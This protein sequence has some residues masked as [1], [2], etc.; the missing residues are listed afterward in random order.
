[1][2][3][4]A[5]ARGRYRRRAGRRARAAAPW[6]KC[7]H[8]VKHRPCLKCADPK[9]LPTRRGQKE[10]LEGKESKNGDVG[11]MQGRKMRIW[12]TLFCR[13][14]LPFVARESYALH[15]NVLAWSGLGGKEIR[16]YRCKRQ[17]NSICFLLSRFSIFNIRGHS[18]MTSVERGR[19]GVSQILTKEDEVAW[20]WY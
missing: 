8:T 18:Q 3:T 14:I 16:Q 9:I 11:R 5:Y 2:G 19:E 6:L 13:T 7:I 10:E 4:T 12:A 15:S 20:I 1:M 17:R